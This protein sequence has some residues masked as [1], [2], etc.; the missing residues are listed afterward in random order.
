MKSR[1][2]PLLAWQ[3]MRRCYT[4]HHDALHYLRLISV[5]LIIRACRLGITK[6]FSQMEQI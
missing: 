2:L 5:P 1:P 6:V 4:R 3:T